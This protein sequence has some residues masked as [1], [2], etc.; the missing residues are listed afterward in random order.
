MTAM[1]NSVLTIRTWIRVTV[2]FEAVASQ[3]IKCRVFGPAKI[4]Y[5]TG[6]AGQSFLDIYCHRIQGYGNWTVKR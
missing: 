3:D 5:A 2:K 1:M 6:Y 4:I